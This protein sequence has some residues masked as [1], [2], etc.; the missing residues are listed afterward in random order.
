M[1]YSNDKIS[2]ANNKEIY[3]STV[4]EQRSKVADVENLKK[5]GLKGEE[6]ISEIVASNSSM[7][8]RTLLSQEKILK[9]MEVRHK[10]QISLAKPSIFNLTET[11]FLDKIQSKIL[12]HMRFDTVCTIMQKCKFIQ[13]S[14]SVIYDLSNGFLTSVLATRST[15]TIFSLFESRPYQRMIPYFNLSPEQ[16]SIISYF[17]YKK[18]AESLTQDS[19][20]PFGFNEAFTNIIVCHRDEF[21][22]VEIVGSLISALKN[23]GNL[24]V[25]ARDKEVSLKFINIST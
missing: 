7:C 4:E 3:S 11:M 18:F 14:K 21:K 23:S 2:K 9:R 20:N 25:Y 24:V 17:D 1:D 12:L 10:Y 5:S 8:K 15:G 19:E 22:L 13:Q 16:K 6:L